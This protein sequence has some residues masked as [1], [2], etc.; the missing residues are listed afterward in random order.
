[1]SVFASEIFIHVTP[2]S[3]TKSGVKRIFLIT[4][5]DDPHPG[6]RNAQLVTVARTTLLVSPHFFAKEF[7]LTK[8]FNRT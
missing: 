2:T 4:D 7:A 1:M 6:A 3:A 5:Q 8:N